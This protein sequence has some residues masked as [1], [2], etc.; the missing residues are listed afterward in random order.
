MVKKG[1]ASVAKMYKA[2]YLRKAN[3]YLFKSYRRDISFHT[4]ELT[5]CCIFFQICKKKFKVIKINLTDLSAMFF[6][7]FINYT[8]NIKVTKEKCL[9][10]QF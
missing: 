4:L 2:E 1:Q 6:K 9:T 8:K 3:P 7:L 5:L 10:Y